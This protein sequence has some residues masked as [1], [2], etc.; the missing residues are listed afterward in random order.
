TAD[1]FYEKHVGG[2]LQPPRA[3][4]VAEFPELVRFEFSVKE[5]T[6]IVFAGLGWITVTE[7]GVVA[8]WAPK[9]VDVLRRK[10]LI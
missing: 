2:L 6:D 7:P 1:A 3:D 4:E 8:G 5:K 9:G 10:S